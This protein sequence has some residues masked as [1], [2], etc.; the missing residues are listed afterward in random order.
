MTEITDFEA[1]VLRTIPKDEYFE[2]PTY[3]IW[4]ESLMKTV[5][6]IEGIDPK[7][8]R[9]VISSLKQKGYI[10]IDTSN[11][12]TSIGLEEKGWLWLLDNKVINERGELLEKGL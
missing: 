4:G 2:E 8:T 3:P 9:G 6:R 12:E 10:W 5:K 1:K 11:G 7:Q